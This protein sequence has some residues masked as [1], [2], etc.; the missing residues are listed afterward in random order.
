MIQKKFGKNHKILCFL[1]IGLVICIAISPFINPDLGLKEK[2]IQAILKTEPIKVETDTPIIYN[3][4]P[5]SLYYK[6]GDLIQLTVECDMANYTLTANFSLI[7]NQYLPGDDTFIDYNNG[8]YRILYTIN[9]S[10]T[11][12]DGL[13]QVV[14]NVTNVTSGFS[15]F[16]NDT[17]LN[18]DNTL[19]NLYLTT[20]Y[21]GAYLTSNNVTIEGYLNATGSLIKLA[22]IN[23]T[24]FG[25][26]GNWTGL[27][28]GKFTIVNNSKIG[29]GIIRLRINLI[30]SVDLSN[31][32]TIYFT[33]DNSNPNITRT[34]TSVSNNQLLLGLLLKGT[35]SPITSFSYN[36]SQFS[37][38]ISTNP[39]GKLEEIVILENPSSSIPDGHY[40]LN[41]TITDSV[42]F[43]N[44]LLYPFT[45]D[46]TP[47]T[48][49]GIIRN[50]SKPEYFEDVTITIL[51]PQDSVSGIQS[52]S[53]QYS[54]N[55]GSTW[56]ITNITETNFGIIP[57]FA[58]NTKVLYIIEIIDK[59]G[60]INTSNIY[61]YTVNDTVPPII[62][63]IQHTPSSPTQ[64]NRVNI[65]IGFAIDIGAGIASLFL[66]YSIDS[67]ISWNF[68]NITENKWIL[69]EKLSANTKVVYQII[70]Y[71]KEGNQFK[72]DFMSYTV[73]FN[74]SRLLIILLILVGIA[75]VST[76]SAYRVISIWRKKGLRVKFIN[77]KQELKVYVDL[78]VADVDI[79]INDIKLLDS[80]MDQLLSY[81]W[82]PIKQGVK[83]DKTYIY[84]KIMEYIGIIQISN[85]LSKLKID[86]ENRI[87]AF[88]RNFHQFK[89]S[90]QIL[91]NINVFYEKMDIANMK[92]SQLT[93]NS[94]NKISKISQKT[95][96]L[97]KIDYPLEAFDEIF[98]KNLNK[99]QEAYQNFANEFDKMLNSR[100]VETIESR[101]TEISQIFNDSTQWLKKAE[102]W[103][104]TL[105]LPKDRG[106]KHLLK[107]KQMQY[108]SV[109]NDLEL[110]IEKLR[111]KLTSAVN[112]AQ[113]F[114]SWNYNNLKTRLN[115]FETV[116]NEDIL[117]FITSEK[118]DLSQIE[119]FLTE[120]FDQFYSMLELDR[121]KIIEFYSSHKE[122][123]IE[124]LFENW[125]KFAA[126][127]PSKLENI[128]QGV[129]NL[130]EPL[131]RLF[132]LIT[133]ITS[134][135][136]SESMRQ[137][138]KFQRLETEAVKSDEKLSPLNI[139]LSKTIWTI[140]R[141]DTEITTWINMLPF[142]LET[143]QLM[144]MLRGWNETKDEVLEKINSLSEEH[145]VYRCE[146]MHEILDPLND[147]IWE[148][149][150]CGAISCMDHLERWYHRKKAPECFK[151]GQN[152][153]FKLKTY[154]E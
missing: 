152:N 116:I 30:D 105:P 55:N 121:A 144:I 71:D 112:F 120:K 134:N 110:K 37:N 67:G 138:T 23:D 103:S 52:I 95:K 35:F 127:I 150:N 8:T 94:R 135:F 61:S 145:K 80:K 88:Q 3:V 154:T 78:R 27:M 54:T 142:E 100:M 51:N 64:F 13:Y 24:R 132:N 118:T 36:I 96:T 136:Y 115:K 130:I 139:L 42:N 133:G 108:Q 117:R 18:L 83:G 124:E 57:R 84:Q 11:R 7:D 63:N 91:Q 97:Q 75:S 31:F 85:E 32:T 93:S 34:V 6:N 28:G 72:S 65:S 60:N 111:A 147:Q 59:K 146:I 74:P 73:H 38:L 70:A 41:I 48:Y 141:I 9:L 106:Y 68:I 98:A 99:F 50:I 89:L 49:S 148:C 1:L 46:Q 151:C 149:S 22:S 129:Y 26:T 82:T 92:L 56:V 62:E 101:F 33:L 87:Q 153:T 81:R 21:R 4:S 102:E 107:L 20:P 90:S 53:L 29:E 123:K 143:S 109:K 76:Y 104:R 45:F 40:T 58:Y 113:D 39:I 119:Q 25:F 10:N 2:K 14:I 122:F 5:F 86:F 19:P 17:Y 137:I 16:F 131:H 66:N 79:I 69:I 128:K 126:E 44:S 47:P 15:Q 77:Q 12:S 125:N 43:S 114:I 140:N